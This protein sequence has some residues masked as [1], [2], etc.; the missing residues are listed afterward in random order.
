M[1]LVSI[2]GDS[3]STYEG[4]NP[5]GYAVFYNKEMCKV[6]GLNSVYDTWWA[7]VNQA[8]H[9]YLCVNNSYSGSKVSG[10]GF[11]A[12]SSEERL[13]NL[14]TAE[15]NPD[16]ILVYLGFNDFANGVKIRPDNAGWFSKDKRNCCYFEA[17]YDSMLK[18]IISAYPK[19]KIVCGTLLRTYI[20]GKQDWYFPERFGGVE[21]EKYN[22][23]IKKIV[24]INKCY[25]ADVSGYSMPYETLDGSHPT[26]NGHIVI[27]KAWINCLAQLKLPEL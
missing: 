24:K 23:A 8:L 5:S 11:P 26:V 17:A 25:L 4:Y 14:R 10:D 1:R 27:A 18:K 2:V 19:S 6:N 3:I 7:K 13:K 12:G 22:D 20:K 16:I 15:Y 21:L 9:A